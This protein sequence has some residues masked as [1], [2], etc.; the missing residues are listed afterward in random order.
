[1]DEKLSGKVALVTGG[2]SGI[3]AGACDAFARAGAAVAV[4]DVRHEPATAVVERIQADGGRALAGVADVGD[5]QQISAVIQRTVEEFG[6]LH[7]VFANAGINGMQCPIEQ[8]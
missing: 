1:M 2:G 7:V 6:A 5:E 4:V 8:M 3:G